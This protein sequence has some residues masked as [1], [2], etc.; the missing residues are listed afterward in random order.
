[1][2]PGSCTEVTDI[3]F[4]SKLLEVSEL[5]GVSD[6]LLWLG[7]DEVEDDVEDDELEWLCV[8][9]DLMF[10]RFIQSR[11]VLAGMLYFIDDLLMLEDKIIY[12]NKTVKS[13]IF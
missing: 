9:T 2:V 10:N 1:M 11:N 7:L 3:L 4:F 8:N 5:L 12:C 6:D 13:E